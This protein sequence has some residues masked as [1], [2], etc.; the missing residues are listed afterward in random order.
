MDWILSMKSVDFFFY[1]YAAFVLGQ[2]QCLLECTQQNVLPWLP[3]TNTGNVEENVLNSTIFH[4]SCS[5][6]SYAILISTTPHFHAFWSTLFWYQSHMLIHHTI[7]TNPVLLPFL[8]PTLIG[9]EMVR[10]WVFKISF[11]AMF[12][13]T[14]LDN[15]C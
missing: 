2:P 4:G 12:I 10:Y 9:L 5:I 3:W 11:V 1:P 8:L 13:L 6:S 14:L 7:N 15:V